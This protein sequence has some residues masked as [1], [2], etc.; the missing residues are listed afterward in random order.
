M[1]LALSAVV[2]GAGE[3]IRRVRAPRDHGLATAAPPGP[4]R[5]APRCPAPR[6]SSSVVCAGTLCHARSRRAARSS[7]ETCPRA[8]R[9][10]RGREAFAA[11]EGYDGPAAPP[12][13]R[14]RSSGRRARRRGKASCPGAPRRGRHSRQT[15]RCA[16]PRALPATARAPCTPG[17]EERSRLRLRP[18]PAGS[19]RGGLSGSSGARSA[20]AATR[21]SPKSVTRARPS[22]PRSTLSGEITV[23]QAGG[24]RGGEPR[25]ASRSSFNAASGER[26]SARSHCPRVPP[27]MNSMVRK[28]CSS[29]RP[30]SNTVIT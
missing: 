23:N 16:R 30:A 11:T 9:R 17:A 28:T 24:V 18:D 4:P 27:S 14:A 26:A 10:G 2:P 15:D 5:P 7:K 19:G 13:A 12:G 8:R 3:P 6:P 22:L 1:K 25:P 29:K 21:A 20:T